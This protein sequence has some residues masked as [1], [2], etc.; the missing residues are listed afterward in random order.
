[1]TITREDL[2]FWDTRTLERRI[3]KGQL[4]RKDV[5]KHLKSLPDVADKGQAPAIEAVEAEEDDYDDELD[6]EP[7]EAVNGVSE[8]DVSPSEE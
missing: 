3:R 1:M 6:E 5:D 4:S 8:G 7:V 2:R